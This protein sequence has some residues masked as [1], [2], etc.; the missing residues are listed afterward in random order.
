MKNQRISKDEVV[1]YTVIYDLKTLP[2]RNLIDPEGEFHIQ[3]ML[4]S[5]V[6][7]AQDYIKWIIEK[8]KSSEVELKDFDILAFRVHDDF[9][10]DSLRQTNPEFFL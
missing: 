8:T 10:I 4:F 6:Q 9:C 1:L 2:Q 3:G 7:K 5:S